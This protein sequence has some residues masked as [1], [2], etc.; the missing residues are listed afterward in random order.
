MTRLLAGL[1]DRIASRRAAWVIVA[2]WTVLAIGLT[3]LA[4]KNPAPPEAFAFTLPAS[5]ESS[6]VDKLIARDFPQ[7]KGVAATIVLYRHG[8]R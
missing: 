8:G 3:V 7:S 1:T 6:K 4:Q 5:A 2:A